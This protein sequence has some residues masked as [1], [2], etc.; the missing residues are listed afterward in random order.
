M[1]IFTS[2]SSSSMDISMYSSKRSISSSS[3][4]P[5]LIPRRRFGAPPQRRL[6][7]NQAHAFAFF[8]DSFVSFCDAA[9]EQFATSGLDG[10]SVGGEGGEATR[11]NRRKV[12]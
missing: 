7:D 12:H 6:V 9:I 4:F 8:S 3:A 11:R 2:I 1:L 5:G 10:A